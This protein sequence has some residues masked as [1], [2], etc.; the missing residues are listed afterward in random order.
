MKREVF[1]VQRQLGAP[2]RQAR[3]LIYNK[4]RS[5]TAELSSPPPGLVSM[6]SRRVMKI[7]VM[8]YVDKEGILRLDTKVPEQ[9]W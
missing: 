7:Y 6:F 5:I 8:G 1:K 9:D 2:R 4:D 3:V